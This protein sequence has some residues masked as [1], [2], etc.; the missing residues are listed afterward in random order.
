MFNLKEVLLAGQRDAYSASDG[1]GS[2]RAYDAIVGGGML[3]KYLEF[4]KM[5]ELK[6]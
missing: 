5:T 1:F 6:V 3:L 4:C 2:N